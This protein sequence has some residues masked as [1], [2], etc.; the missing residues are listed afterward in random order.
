MTISPKKSPKSK[1]VRFRISKFWPP[2]FA[3]FRWLSRSSLRVTTV[4]DCITLH[5]IKVIWSGPSTRLLNHWQLPVWTQRTLMLGC[6]LGYTRRYFLNRLRHFLDGKTISSESRRDSGRTRQMYG[7]NQRRWQ[8]HFMHEWI[9]HIKHSRRRIAYMQVT[10]THTQTYI[11]TYRDR[12][13]LESGRWT[14]GRWH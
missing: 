12:Q 7:Y 6:G 1:C 13:I 2:N 10:S 14:V 3:T 11:R 4:R 8:W 5:Y 9:E